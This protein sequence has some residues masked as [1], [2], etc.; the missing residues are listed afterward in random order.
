MA[1]ENKANKLIAYKRWMVRLDRWR[2]SEVPANWSSVEAHI[3]EA[4]RIVSYVFHNYNELPRIF[5]VSY[6]MK[7]RLVYALANCTDL[8]LE[9]GSRHVS[10]KFDSS[11]RVGFKFC[12]IRSKRL[13]A[14]IDSVSNLIG[15]SLNGG[16]LV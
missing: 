9:I 5:D 1:T 13:L 3:S 15:F 11:L 6:I 10:I 7:F 4:E 8:T 14:H 16:K 12:P 2:G